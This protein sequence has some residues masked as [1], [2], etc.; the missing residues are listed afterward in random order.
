M[1]KFGIL[2]FVIVLGCQ[3]LFASSSMFDNDGKYSGDW[4]QMTRVNTSHYQPR[5][6]S[7]NY[8]THSWNVQN[9]KNSQSNTKDFSVQ[10]YNNASVAPFRYNSLNYTR[11]RQVQG[12]HGEYNAKC[13]DIGDVSF[14]R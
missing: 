9:K 3:P 2:I 11:T 1:Y 8:S 5:Y 10:N 12:G 4:K 14:C 6:S 7:S 13:T